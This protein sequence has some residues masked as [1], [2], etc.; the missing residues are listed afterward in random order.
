M[1][2]AYQCAAPA[3]SILTTSMIREMTHEQLRGACAARSYRNS[4]RGSSEA[5]LRSVLEL[6][7][8][9]DLRPPLEAMSHSMREETIKDDYHRR[10]D[11]C[12]LSDLPVALP[13]ELCK[14]CL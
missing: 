10:I 14:V 4:F 6:D 12:S 2:R 3:A 1:L 8:V 13:P 9:P 5:V 7:A 11:A